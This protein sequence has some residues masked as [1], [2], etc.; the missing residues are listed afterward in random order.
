MQLVYGNH[1]ISSYAQS[2][3]NLMILYQ[4]LLFSNTLNQKEDKRWDTVSFKNS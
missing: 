2:L 4:S 3:Y 1:N